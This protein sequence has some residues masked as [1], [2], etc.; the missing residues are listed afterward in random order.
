MAY[1]ALIAPKYTKMIITINISTIKYVTVKS[2]LL[3]IKF[4]NIERMTYNALVAPIE[5]NASN[6][7]A[8]NC[9]YIY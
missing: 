6:A 8:Q 7:C 3:K 4:L 9:I 1:N 2:L 5:Y